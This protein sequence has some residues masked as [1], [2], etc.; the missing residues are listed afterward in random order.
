[1]YYLEKAWNLSEKEP[2]TN[3]VS[4]EIFLK[5][6]KNYNIF[7][8]TTCKKYNLDG[9]NSQI[10]HESGFTPGHDLIEQL[11][12]NICHKSIGWKAILHSFVKTQQ[13]P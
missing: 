13:T 5:R 9:V 7:C 12:R 11:C 2:A 8:H 10:S 1:M 6:F 4:E 3:T